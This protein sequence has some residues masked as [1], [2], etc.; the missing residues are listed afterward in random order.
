MKTIGVLG[1]IGPQATI[2][3]ERR[4]HRVSQELI[5]PRGNQGYPPMVTWYLRHGPVLLDERERPSDP[6]TLDPRLLEAA[7]KLGKVSDFLVIPSNTPHFFLEEIEAAAGVAVLSIV[8]VTVAELRARG[9]RRVGLCG[10][11]IPK[12]YSVRLEDEGFDVVVA[13]AEQREALDGSIIRLMEGETD[14]DDRRHATE[15][16]A[17]L[18]E[19]DVEV[20]I[21]GCSEI[22]LLLGDASAAPDL[23]NPTELL[24]RAAVRRAI[25]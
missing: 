13:S 5:P 25:G 8:D 3:F 6:L 22:P 17:A 1:G 10:L 23:L 24:A 12:V 4:V 18:R 14:D 16:V 20:A 7:A 15:V 19:Q 2:D 9:A 21:L 11:G